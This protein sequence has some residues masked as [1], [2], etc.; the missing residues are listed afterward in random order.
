MNAPATVCSQIMADIIRLDSLG[1]VPEAFEIAALKRRAQALKSSDYAEYWMVM[2]ALSALEQD[3]DKTFE[4]AKTAVPLA[5][6]DLLIANV[7]T[8]VFNVGLLFEALEIIGTAFA[9]FQGSVRVAAIE[10]NLSYDSGFFVRSK[11]AADRLRKMNIKPQREDHSA[12]ASLLEKRGFSEKDLCAVLAIAR[13][14][15]TSKKIPVKRQFMAA[16]ASEDGIRRLTVAFML[17][18]PVRELL[19]VEDGLIDALIAANL[20]IERQDCVTLSLS[21]ASSTEQHEHHSRELA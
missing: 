19:D 20:P 11:I 16:T 17:H 2:T 8:S 12:Y 10:C 21:S 5:N 1:K 4:Y 15:M 13:Q 7:A 9:R 6:H 3:K 18:M 14:Y